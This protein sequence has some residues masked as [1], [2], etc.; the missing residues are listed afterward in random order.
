MSVLSLWRGLITMIG[1]PFIRRR[2]ATTVI[3]SGCSAVIAV[4]IS[5]TVKDG[6]QRHWNSISGATLSPSLTFTEQKPERQADVA[7]EERGA[8]GKAPQSDPAPITAAPPYSRELAQALEAEQHLGGEPEPQTKIAAPALAP[9]EPPNR[10][11]P[12]QALEAVIAAQERGRQERAAKEDAEMNKAWETAQAASKASALKDFVRRYPQSPQAA[13][14]RQ[15]ADQHAALEQ[16]PQASDPLVSNSLDPSE[17]R[18]LIMRYPPPGDAV[19]PPSAPIR[20]AALVIGN[21]AYQNVA[22]LPNPVKDADAVAEMFRAA[23]F[24]S[25]QLL[26]NLG[27][28]DFKRA[29]QR[30]EDAAIGADIAVI[31]YSGHAIEINGTNYILPVDAKLATDVPAPHYEFGSWLRDDAIELDRLI[32][33]VHSAKRLSLVILVACLDNSFLKTV[34]RQ[35]QAMRSKPRGGLSAPGDIGADTLVAYAAKQDS[36]ADDCN[37]QHS[38]FTP[39]SWTTWALRDS[40]SDWPS[41]GFATRF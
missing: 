32:K 40:T 18:N 11:E 9:A 25:V 17:L 41:G 4:I 30:F 10:Q 13:E 33:S 16:E 19:A 5:V 2:L 34:G 29:I 35:R 14:A 6:M 23:G 15:L 26:A 31:F 21:S 37:G 3:A 27:N 20:R 1:E 36:T 38:P 7:A 12:P 24:E 22:K 28:L 8:P 39:R